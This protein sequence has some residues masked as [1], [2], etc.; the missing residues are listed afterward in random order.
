MPSRG[1][2]WPAMLLLVCAALARAAFA[3][4][5]TDEG[6]DQ[7]P[8]RVEVSVDVVGTAPLPGVERRYD[9]VPAPVQTARSTDLAARGSADLS[10]FLNHRFGGV[11][12]NEIQGNPF[13]ADLNF[14]GYTASPLLGTPQGL[15]V[16]MDGVRL[17]QPFGEVVNWDLI[18]RAAIASSTLMPGS[19]PLFGL[20]TL[21]GAVL[22]QTKTGRTDPGTA[23]EATYGSHARRA[24]EIEH[25]GYSQNGFDWFL[26]GNL[27]S[28]DG[29]R[30][31]SPSE[32]RQAFGKLGWTRVRTAA[33]VTVAFADNSLIGNGLQEV[34]LLERDYA[35]I[36]TKPDVTDTRST[37]V[38]GQFRRYLSGSRLSVSANT[39]YRDIDTR[40]LNGDVNDDVLDEDGR[41]DLIYVYTGVQNTTASRQHNYGASG[42]VTLSGAA[43]VAANDFTAGL[44]YDASRVQFDQTAELGFLTAD[45]G[46]IGSGAEDE[47]AA[48]DLRGRVHTWSAYATDTLS[49][50]GR[51]HVT[52]SGRFNRTVVH[53]RD[54]L[55][56]GGGA[57]SLDGDHV[58]R[59]FN[60]AAGMTFTAPLGLNVYAGYSQGSRA[61]TSIELGCADPANPC[62]LPNAMAGDPPLA[63]VVAH[64]WEAGV[65][66]MPSRRV[67]WSA[68]VFRAENHDDIL[69]VSTGLTGYGYFKNFGRTRRQGVELSVEA[70]VLAATIGASYA[71]LDATYR[72]EELVNGESNSTGGED[73]APDGTIA[74]EPGARIPLVPRH[75]LKAYGSVPVGSRVTL[76]ADL[77]GVSGVFARG[78]EN[79]LH[80]PDGVSFLG[81]GAT[82]AYA[83]VNAGARVRLTPW[84][85]AT[86]QVNNVFDRR[87]E[88]AAQLGPTVFTPEGAFAPQP[89]VHSTFVAPGAPR[90]FW[91]GTRVTF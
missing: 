10:D 30:E 58:F 57:G 67:R 37:L 87:Y 21:G 62:R 73:G 45:R 36:Y 82:D 43:S 78:N 6:D 72:S 64:T 83:V 27:F 23:I 34:R 4:P 61:A 26:T 12:V 25:G 50:D 24:V 42:Q 69:F 59:R 35:G 75:L 52:L 1:I 47:E 48:V 16:Y 63:Q 40:T 76:D 79:N 46:V 8:P 2:R 41:L 3:Q 56:P 5:A 19:N 22:V 32:V 85:Q 91:V 70:P 7:Q 33:A 13:Q 20:N 29:W 84:L 66:S 90:L 51:W 80:E 18:P 49:I 60:P 54:G 44:A 74:I 88:S 71:F 31:D 9:E 65:R 53:N 14:R 55:E 28:D 38:N 89:L 39:Y 81:P 86:A 77:V 15:S 68:G 17:N 11:H